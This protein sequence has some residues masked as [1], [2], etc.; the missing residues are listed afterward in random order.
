MLGTRP[1][2]PRRF[3]GAISPRYMG[4]TLR[5]TPA[6]SDQ[7]RVQRGCSTPQPLL[8][9][10]P[11]PAPHPTSTPPVLPEWMPVMKRP[12]MIISGEARARLKPMRALARKTSSVLRTRVPFLPGPQGA[13]HPGVALSP[14][15]T[16]VPSHL[17]R[18]LPPPP[19]QAVPA[20]SGHQHPHGQGPHQPPQRKDGDGQRVHEGE[21]PGAQALPVAL[22][23]GDV[24]ESLDVL[25]G[26]RRRQVGAGGGWP[27]SGLCGG[28][29]C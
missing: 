29:D 5:Q 11:C 1:R 26:E 24:V 22:G 28:P 18:L 2:K 4:T 3:L 7:P 20:V 21:E 9:P 12:V 15:A 25:Q 19:A 23:P 13:S 10:A 6:G 17:V 27:G 8:P 16:A 14:E